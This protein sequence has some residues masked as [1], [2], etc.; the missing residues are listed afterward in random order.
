MVSDNFR[1]VIWGVSEST[2]GSSGGVQEK[3]LKIQ[4]SAIKI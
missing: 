1:T 2:V 4:V 3:F